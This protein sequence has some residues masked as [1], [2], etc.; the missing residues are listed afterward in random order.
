MP[1]HNLI[2]RDLTAEERTSLC[3]AIG[4]YFAIV[5][6]HGLV[7]EPDPDTCEVCDSLVRWWHGA[8][9][10]DRPDADT[11]ISLL[12]AVVGDL[13]RHAAWLEWKYVQNEEDE[14]L[15]LVGGEDAPVVIAVFD[16]MAKR[17]HEHPE[18]FVSDFF[19]GLFEH[20]GH[21]AR[22]EDDPPPASLFPED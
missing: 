17:L 21:L 1:E 19:E 22:A 6:E 20:V 10:D 11:I 5:E 3:D 8:P 13:L 2:T 9:E 7:N 16:S 12:G 4:F 15:A 14:Y 18:G